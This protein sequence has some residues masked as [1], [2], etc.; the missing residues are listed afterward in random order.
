MLV[1]YHAGPGY[2]SGLYIASGL[3]VPPHHQVGRF[4]DARRWQRQAGLLFGR[5]GLIQELKVKI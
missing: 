2:L 3:F 4:P 5:R 1:E